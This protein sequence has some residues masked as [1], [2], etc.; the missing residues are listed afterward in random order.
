M[1]ITSTKNRYRFYQNATT[2]DAVLGTTSTYTS[3][4]SEASFGVGDSYVDRIQNRDWKVQVAKGVNASTNY[5]RVGQEIS[6]GSARCET[7]RKSDGRYRGKDI[8]R[9]A[10]A[11][12]FAV[13]TDS[14]LQNLALSRLKRKL[15]KQT[16]SMNAMAPLGEL[17][18]LGVTIRGIKELTTGVLST[19]INI[20]R[21]RGA[22][23]Y[24]YAAKAWLTFNFGVSP[25][26]S[27]FAK[28]CAS[29]E[30]YL[31]NADHTV[32]LTGSAQKDWFTNSSESNITGCLGATAK[33]KSVF[34]QTLSYKYVA[35]FDL[36]IDSS[37][38][39]GV[40]QHFGLGLP[41]LLPTIW[42]LTAFSW[43]VDYFTNVGDFLEDAFTAPPGVTK[44][45][46]LNRR[47]TV[48]VF[49]TVDHTLTAEYKFVSNSPGMSYGRYYDFQRTSLSSLPHVGLDF[50][51]QQQI[52][53]FG[54]SKVLNL[55][56]VLV[57]GPTSLARKGR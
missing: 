43:V 26:L 34:Y 17:K 39:Y 25:L 7:L 31:T 37:N 19:L 20:K 36:K 9:I 27:D 55:A 46:V 57:S 50:K 44:Y 40:G 10:P 14:A 42:E 41:Q 8:L 16:G 12:T 2:Y 21:T 23:A 38:D 22:S 51:T 24:K 47:H 1:T 32:R 15:S 11:W 56:S 48:E 52:G 6:V 4:S 30:K 28:A 54:L 3:G 5:R 29:I 13:A 53:S 33:S 49:S 45:V 35:G 18:D